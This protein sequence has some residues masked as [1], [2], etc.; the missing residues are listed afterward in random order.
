MGKPSFGF[1][2]RTALRVL[3]SE[4]AVVYIPRTNEEYIDH[5]TIG[6]PPPYALAGIA[7]VSQEEAGGTMEESIRWACDELAKDELLAE[8][9]EL[10]KP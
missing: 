10:L 9:K 4:W 5:C 3:L 8:A 2:L 6:D 7:F 1:R